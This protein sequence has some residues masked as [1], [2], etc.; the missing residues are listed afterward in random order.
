[1]KK[2]YQ[3][4]TVWFNVIALLVVV[5]QRM[6]ELNIGDPRMLESVLAVGNLFLR[7]F[8]TVQPVE[9]KLL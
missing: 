3:S 4:R 1:M 8:S 6:G 9:K 2:W 5:L 7:V